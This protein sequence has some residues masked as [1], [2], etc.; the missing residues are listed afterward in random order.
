MLSSDTLAV[1][2]WRALERAPSEA[3][4]GGFV[5]SGSGGMAEDP[6]LLMTGHGCHLSAHDLELLIGYGGGRKRI[7]I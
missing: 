2:P 6:V 4:R 1:L 7:F 5:E 3:G